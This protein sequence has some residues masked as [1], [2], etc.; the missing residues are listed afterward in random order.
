[1]L[2]QEG[3]IDKLR[4]ENARFR[5]IMMRQTNIIDGLR[6]RVEE[7]SALLPQ[8]TEEDPIVL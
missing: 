6:K 3:E 7:V 2:D 4:L 1:M 8:G 5:G